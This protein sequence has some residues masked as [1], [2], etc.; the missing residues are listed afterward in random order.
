MELPFSIQLLYC[1]Q[2]LLIPIQYGNY[3]FQKD[4]R[5]RK[6]FLFVLIAFATI[7]GSWIFIGEISL[8]NSLVSVTP[9]ALACTFGFSVFFYFISTS[10]SFRKGNK[11]VSFKRI[12][13][14]GSLVFLAII[15]KPI[16]NHF[17]TK[18]GG[19][20]ILADLILIILI[21]LLL[22]ISF[23]R[24]LIEMVS[25]PQYT[26]MEYCIL[27]VISILFV[28]PI[29]LIL[30]DSF[31]LKFTISNIPFFVICTSY[32]LY[33]IEGVKHRYRRLE[34]LEKLALKN[35]FIKYDL[36]PRE[37]ELVE[38]FEEGYS[39]DEMIK[40]LFVSV[41]GFRKLRSNLYKKFDLKVR[42]HQELE[43]F[44]L[45]RHSPENL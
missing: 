6:S 10:S 3:S 32:L 27:I 25:R 34:K 40:K 30:L 19:A 9:M 21:E 7:N 43:K 18:F 4:D 5:V 2:V 29:V 39:K 23:M 33:H 35:Q 14:L 8:S 20:D 1:L 13:A 41:D 37:L 24:T 45:N 15:T 12:T 22:T 44:I 11:E 31:E 42:T 17:V 36:T 26:H 38:L 16:I 28:L